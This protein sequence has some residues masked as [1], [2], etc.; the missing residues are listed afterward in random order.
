[1]AILHT[2][3]ESSNYYEKINITLI[4]QSRV[5]NRVRA[6]IALLSTLKISYHDAVVHTPSWA[7]VDK[8]FTYQLPGLVPGF[9]LLV[10]LCTSST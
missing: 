8:Y 5:E 2:G 7:S 3:K 6:L 4:M 1:M 10:M 9:L